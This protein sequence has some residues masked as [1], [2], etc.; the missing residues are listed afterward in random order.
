MYQVVH[1]G[2]RRRPEMPLGAEAQRLHGCP[3]PQ[4][5]GDVDGNLHQRHYGPDLQLHGR[6]PAQ[7]DVRDL[8]R[9]TGSCT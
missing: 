8:Q 7:V 2:H 4:M 5:L 9:V 1:T 6:Q 3:E